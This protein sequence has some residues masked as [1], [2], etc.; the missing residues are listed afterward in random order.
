MALPAPD[1]ISFEAEKTE[2]L[3]LLGLRAPVQRIG[4]QLFNGVTTVT[5]KVRYLSV[6]VWIVWRYFRI[7]PAQQLEVVHF[8]RGGTGS[9]DRHGKPS[10]EPIHSESGWRYQSRQA[11]GFRQQHSSFGA[12]RPTGGL[13]HLRHDESAAQFDP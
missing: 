9:H 10:Q 8:I 13:Q 4:N 5:P 3:D 12:P 11:L 1:W 2:G 7:A 6:L